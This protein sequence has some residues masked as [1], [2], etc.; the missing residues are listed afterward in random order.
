MKPGSVNAIPF[1]TLSL[2]KKKK[3][4]E[5]NILHHVMAYKVVLHISHSKNN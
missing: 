1:N 5:T 4:F 2:K 3:I